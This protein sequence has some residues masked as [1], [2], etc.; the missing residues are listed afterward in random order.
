MPMKRNVSLK[1]EI[2]CPSERMKATP[3]KIAIVPSVAITA[4]TRP[5]GDDQAVEEAGE[6]ADDEPGRDAGRSAD[7]STAI[8][9]AV[10]TVVKPDDRADGNVE[11]AR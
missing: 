10:D 11:A 3:R 2:D 1:I 9:I 7:P 8:A 6:A 4:L 5:I